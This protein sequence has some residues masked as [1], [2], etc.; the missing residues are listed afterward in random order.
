[1]NKIN[2]LKQKRE[3]LTRLVKKFGRQLTASQDKLWFWENALTKTE[4]RKVEKK[5]ERVLRERERI[6]AK[7]GWK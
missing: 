3:L 2:Y 1:M 4:G 5:A 6:K 7:Y